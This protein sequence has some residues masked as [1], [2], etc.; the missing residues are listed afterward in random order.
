M[1]KIQYSAQSARLSVQLSKWV[2]PKITSGQSKLTARRITAVDGWFSR[3]LCKNGWTDRDAVCVVYLDACKEACVTWG[4][5]WRYLSNTRL[6]PPCAASTQP[7]VKL[8]W[9]LVIMA[10]L[11]SRWGHYIFALWFLL[12][13]FYL[14]LFPCLI[15]VVAE[16]MSTIL[17]HTMWSWCELRMQVWNVLHA[18][19]WKYRTQKWCK[20]SPSV[21]HR[22]TLP[23]WIFATKACINNRKKLVKQQYLLHTS[24]QFGEPRPTSGWDRFVS[25]GHPCK[26]QWLSLLGIVTARHSTTGRQPNFAALNRGRHLYS[27]GRP[28]RWALA[29]ILVI[30]IIRWL[31]TFVDAMSSSTGRSA[32]TTTLSST[33]RPLI[34]VTTLGRFASEPPT[35]TS[36]RLLTVSSSTSGSNS[37]CLVDTTTDHRSATQF[38]DLLLDPPLHPIVRSFSSANQRFWFRHTRIHWT[39][40]G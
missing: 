38:N 13:F 10:A 17:V 39:D 1:P 31:V 11:R 33:S 16:W 28:S 30:H 22:T 29:H 27:A 3:E 40:A 4:A 14:F 9:P 25:L 35:S 15:S 6:N 34:A 2:C 20:K 7:F 26:F 8:L 37:N 5:H 36:T 23:G 24:A 32:S 21:H 19:R 12:S 18:A